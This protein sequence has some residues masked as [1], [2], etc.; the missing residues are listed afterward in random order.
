M[1]K[2]IAGGLG[3]LTLLLGL[4]A[5]LAP[6][7]FYEV[8]APFP[9]YNRHFLH[10]AGAFQIG[11]GATLLLALR[12]RDSLLVVLAGYA[13]GGA[14]HA[15]AHLLDRQLGGR[16]TDAPL[17]LILAALAVAALLVPKRA[18]GRA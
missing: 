4:W 16:G 1:G 10:D 13:I 11:I 14:C 7:S 15:L 6:A 12:W 2:V 8:I 17:L 3:V 5:L 9:P 18:G